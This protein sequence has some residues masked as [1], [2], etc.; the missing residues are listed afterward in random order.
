M[1]RKIFTISIDTG[2]TGTGDKDL[3]EANYKK[4][5]FTKDAYDAMLINSLSVALGVK[6]GNM[7]RSKEVRERM[8]KKAVALLR[9]TMEQAAEENGRA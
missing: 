3:K 7:F 6:M 1:N 2:D 5:G 4:L 9:Q 8:F